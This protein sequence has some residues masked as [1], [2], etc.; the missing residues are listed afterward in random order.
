M[1]TGVAAPCGGQGLIASAVTPQ[2]Q[3]TLVFFLSLNDDQPIRLSGR[4]E[5]PQVPLFLPASTGIA[6]TTTFLMCSAH[7][8]RVYTVQDSLPTAGASCGSL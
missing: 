1:S 3:A 5:S 2:E 8:R 6:H 4:Q 7:C